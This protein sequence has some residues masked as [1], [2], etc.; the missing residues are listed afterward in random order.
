MRSIEMWWSEYRLNT[1][2]EAKSSFLKGIKHC[3]RRYEQRE[4]KSASVC[5]DTDNIYQRLYT[6]LIIRRWELHQ[7]N[8]F[9]QR[10]IT[11]GQDAILSEEA[12]SME[13]FRGTTHGGVCLQMN[14]KGRTSLEETQN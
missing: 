7:A 5:S 13:G 12:W 6:D 4:A 2:D 3:R 8:P 14:C 11:R 10:R 9:E 1:E